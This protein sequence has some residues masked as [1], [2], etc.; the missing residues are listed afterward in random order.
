[1]LRH[2]PTSQ[3]WSH[4][5]QEMSVSHEDV[6]K[7]QNPAETGTQQSYMNYGRQKGKRTSMIR[8]LASFVFLLVA[9]LVLLTLVALFVT[10]LLS[11]LLAL[12]GFLG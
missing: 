6:E 1:M 11:L 5:S 7:F 9:N 8:K 4:S 12:G 2:Q 3:E 10:R